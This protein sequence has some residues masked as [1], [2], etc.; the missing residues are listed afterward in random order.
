MIEGQ[1]EEA[2]PKAAFFVSE[3]YTSSSVTFFL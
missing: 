2:A 3:D 1:P